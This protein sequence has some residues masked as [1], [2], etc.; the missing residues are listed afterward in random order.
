MDPRALSGRRGR[1]MM[2]PM[3]RG[4]SAL[5]GHD[6]RSSSFQGASRW[7]VFLFLWL[8]PLSSAFGNALFDGVSYTNFV[9]P[10]P[11]EIHVLKISRR[12]GSFEIHSV[13][14]GGKPIGRS[15][16]SEQLKLIHGAPIAAINGDFFQLEGAFAGDPRGLQIVDGALISAPAGNGSFWIDSGGAPHI[17]V[18]R[19][20]LRVTWPNGWSARLGLNARCETNEVTLYSGDIKSLP[21]DGIVREIVLLPDG[22]ETNSE[23]RA[24]R[25]YSMT[26][27]EV[28]EANGA[29]IPLGAFV[30]AIGRAMVKNVPAIET[31]AV[32]KIS[33]ATVPNLRGAV[34]AVSGGPILV[35]S[36]KQQRFD[37]AESSAFK[38]RFMV[39][40]HPRTAVGWS[41][42][43]LF[44]VE[45]DGRRKDS[46]GMTLN[47]LGA[48]M[49]ELGCVEAMNLDGGGSSTFWFDG[50]V[51]NRPSDGAER[52]VANSL[53]LVRKPA[54]GK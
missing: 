27:R 15:P 36:G 24:G 18:T 30:L 13:H 54:A 51:R 42:R 50:K 3:I 4:G 14:S 23:L 47:E 33:T 2:A 40:K 20:Q 37:K 38:H 39:E 41:E 43:D 25:V 5:G 16:V 32:L 22:N 7:V 17:A 21:R 6:L 48:L 53:V 19:S 11:I 31:G 28:R 12:E 45:V 44:W 9:R 1:K 49:I 52:P 26:V 35:I 8:W 34:N 29:A 46:V 10:G